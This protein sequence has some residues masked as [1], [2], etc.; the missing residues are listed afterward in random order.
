MNSAFK[1][2]VAMLTILAAGG[3]AVVYSNYSPGFASNLEIAGIY[4]A[5]ICWRGRDS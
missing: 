4:S 3:L 2:M 5:S 1:L